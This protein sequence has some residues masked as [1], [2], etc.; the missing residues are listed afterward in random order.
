MK[1]KNEKDK[2]YEECLEKINN[3]T[4]NK[5]ILSEE[6]LEESIGIMEEIE[7]IQKNLLMVEEE[8]CFSC[9]YYDS[10]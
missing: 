2:L 6:Y 7:D 1:I 9:K 5:E 4:E 3:P 8:S 10:M